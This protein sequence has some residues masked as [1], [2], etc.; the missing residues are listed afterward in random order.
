M[1]LRLGYDAPR[2]VSGWNDARAT[3]RTGGRM[4]DMAHDEGNGKGWV[5]T[6][7]LSLGLWGTVLLGMILFGHHLANLNAGH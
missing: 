2:F 5:L 4:F 7:I 3:V 6:F 1:G